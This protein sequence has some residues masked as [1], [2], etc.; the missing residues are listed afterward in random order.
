[1]SLYRDQNRIYVSSSLGHE[2]VACDETRNVNPSLEF[3]TWT[4]K[5]VVNIVIVWLKL[6]FVSC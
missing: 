2:M 5:K 1:M 4:T 6:L 3:K